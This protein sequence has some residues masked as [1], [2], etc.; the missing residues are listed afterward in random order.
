MSHLLIYGA[1]GYTGELIA[2]AAVARGQKPILAGRREEPLRALAEPL[3]LEWRV[4]DLGDAA[5][6]RALAGVAVVLHCAGPFSRTAKAMMA[7]CLRNRAHYLDITGEIAVF[8]LAFRHDAKAQAAGITV[9]PGVGFDVVPS[10]CLAAHLKARLP[11]ATQLH[12]GF[13]STGR[14]SHGTATTMVENIDAGGAVR[15][16]GA[17]VA[18]PSAHLRR[19][20]D[21]GRGPIGAVSIPWGDVA[22]AY[23]STGIPDIAVFIG[24]P[25]S[26]RWGLSLA[27]TLRPLLAR[28]AIKGWLQRRVDAGPPGPTPAQ[29][30]R[31][32]S[33]LW[34]EVI[35]AAGARRVSRLQAPDGYT[36]TADAA[37]AIAA[38]ALAGRLPVGFQ[39]P[40]RALGADFVLSLPGVTRSDEA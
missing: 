32:R 37:V 28:P 27:R 7:A 31:S 29:R 30:A 12:L 35:D 2:R 3:G 25:A 6:D 4:A 19:T 9:M 22:T 40:S 1:Y 23:H 10:D 18:V 33:Y 8:E 11:T 13:Q 21:F 15:R 5:L 14:T 34:G 39:T 20:I 17:I 24:L 16:G 26:A 36:L 38:E